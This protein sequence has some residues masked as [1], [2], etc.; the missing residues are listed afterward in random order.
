MNKISPSCNPNNLYLLNSSLIHFSITNIHC[1]FNNCTNDGFDY[2]SYFNIDVKDGEYYYS[3]YSSSDVKAKFTK[4]ELFE[5]LN[6]TY[7]HLV[8]TA[9]VNYAVKQDLVGCGIEITY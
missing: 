6:K 8:I 3:R 2:I 5:L 1:S 7:K 9:D 4:N